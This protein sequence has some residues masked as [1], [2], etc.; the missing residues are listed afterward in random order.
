MKGRKRKEGKK[1][2]GEKGKRKEGRKRKKGKKNEGRKQSQKKKVTIFIEAQ[3]QL[4]TAKST[5]SIVIN[6]VW[7]QIQ[8]RSICG[9]F[10]SGN[11]NNSNNK[12]NNNLRQT[13]I[14]K[15]QL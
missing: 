14:N 7:L 9:D 3:H 8:S 11:N 5:T 15:E 12:N 2:K 10:Q 1:R 6:S 4:Y 13:A